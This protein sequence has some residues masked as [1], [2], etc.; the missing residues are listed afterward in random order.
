MIFINTFYIKYNLTE[1]K[2]VRYVINEV[3]HLYFV[4]KINQDCFISHFL[5]LSQYL[6][7]HFLILSQYTKSYKEQF[8]HPTPPRPIMLISK[9]Y[10]FP[11]NDAQH[12]YSTWTH[13]MHTK[14]FISPR[15]P[16]R[17][18]EFMLAFVLHL[19]IL[20][21]YSACCSQEVVKIYF[22]YVYNITIFAW[23]KTHAQCK[24]TFIMCQT[25]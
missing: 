16:T 20:H 24:I 25:T 17:L 1:I 3:Q 7:L 12:T 2:F 10:T 6:I 18:S 23:L 4:F 22:F 14:W 13:E 9:Y 11:M 15:I 8:Y 21:M 19:A 5:L